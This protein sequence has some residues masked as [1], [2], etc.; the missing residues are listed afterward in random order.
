LL[1]LIFL[2][3]ECLSYFHEILPERKK[4]AELGAGGLL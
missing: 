2:I 1:A 4:P 3:L